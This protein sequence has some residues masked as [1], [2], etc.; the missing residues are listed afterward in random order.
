[1]PYIQGITDRS[2]ADIAMRTKKAFFNVS[3]WERIKNNILHIEAT[4]KRFHPN[5][6]ALLAMP[7]KADFN[8]ISGAEMRSLAENIERLRI[9]AK[10]LN[11]TGET[12]FY[13]FADGTKCPDY[14]AVNQWERILERIE[15]RYRE[16]HI[17]R[18]LITGVAICG[19]RKHF[20]RNTG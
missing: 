16:L 19:P 4:L 12:I 2:E 11:T 18:Q 9:A 1:M 20:P 3:D 5:V 7:D 13:T 6:P 10:M 14:A 8:T 17:G 15:E